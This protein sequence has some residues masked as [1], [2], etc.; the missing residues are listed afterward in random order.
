VLAK[1][2]GT[3][4]MALKNA[5]TDPRVAPFLDKLV[6]LEVSGAGFTVREAT[7]DEV[8]AYLEQLF[9]AG[10]LRRPR[11]DTSVRELVDLRGQQR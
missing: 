5:H 11:L 1:N 8:T 3:P 10:E 6:R 7:A 9:P 4:D 2:R